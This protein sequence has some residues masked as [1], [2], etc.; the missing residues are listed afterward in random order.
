MWATPTPGKDS[1]TYPWPEVK[2]SITAVVIGEGITDIGVQSFSCLETM[3]SITIAST[4][5]T[6]GDYAFEYCTGTGANRTA[7]SFDFLGQRSF[8]RLR[9]FGND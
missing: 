6:I 8:R 1:V 3:K 5:K 4:V 2:G 9:E 7:R